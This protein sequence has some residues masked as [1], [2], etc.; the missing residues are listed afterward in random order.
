MTPLSMGFSLFPDRSQLSENPAGAIEISREPLV[1][2]GL[3]H[4]L[5][6]RVG[7]DLAYAV[8]IERGKVT[9]A[10]DRCGASFASRLCIT[11]GAGGWK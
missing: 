3:T 1:L 4:E 11:P 7:G 9:L 10:V 2:A 6:V 8:G 5:L